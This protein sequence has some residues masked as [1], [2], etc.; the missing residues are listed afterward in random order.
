M[1][2]LGVANDIAFLSVILNEV[3]NPEN[4]DLKEIFW[5]LRCWR[6]E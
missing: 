1:L 5:I 6:S 4:S 2:Y 3:K